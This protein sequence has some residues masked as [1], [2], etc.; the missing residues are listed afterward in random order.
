MTTPK[1]GAA[2]NRARF[3]ELTGLVDTLRAAGFDPKVLS[4]HDHA[5]NLLAG[6][7]PVE[8]RLP[9]HVAEIVLEGRPAAAPA[10]PPAQPFYRG[11]T[12]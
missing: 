1:P 11:R 10:P 6:R 12:R 8:E 7:A 3:P 4:I 9:R 5:G 2:D